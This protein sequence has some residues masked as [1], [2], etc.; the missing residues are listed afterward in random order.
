MVPQLFLK[1]QPGLASEMLGYEG[2]KF[3]CYVSQ[4]LDQGE[5]REA[6]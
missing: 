5:V 1:E 6:S 4:S 3:N 2:A